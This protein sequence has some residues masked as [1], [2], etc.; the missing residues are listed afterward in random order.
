M[1]TCKLLVSK[2][3]RQH[4]IDLRVHRQSGIKHHLS[5]A[6]EA[7]N[8]CPGNWPRIGVSSH[9]V[10][11][12]VDHIRPIDLAPSRADLAW[13]LAVILVQSLARDAS[14]LHQ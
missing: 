14:P 5:P 10:T 13:H 7:V 11:P 12:E 1:P 6:L 3:P 8:W 9:R 4:V 2:F